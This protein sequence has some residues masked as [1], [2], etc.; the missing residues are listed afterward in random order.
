M[1]VRNLQI[2]GWGALKPRVGVVVALVVVLVGVV[3]FVAVKLMGS[4]GTSVALPTGATTIDIQGTTQ[5]QQQGIAP[6]EAVQQ[7]VIP[8]EKGALEYGPTCAFDILGAEDD[9]ADVQSYLSE[10]VSQRDALQQEYDLKKQELEEQYAPEISR[11]EQDISEDEAD[12]QRV[13]EYLAELKNRCE[14]GVS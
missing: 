2:F 3:G 8:E 11:L 4:Q 7:E 12:L 13:Q 10:K 9:V 5:S 1:N 6:Q 14:E